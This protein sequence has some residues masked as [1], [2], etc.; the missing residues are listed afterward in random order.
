MKD[1]LWRRAGEM[2]LLFFVNGLIIF[3]AQS[4]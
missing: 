1:E 2:L 3:M 4:L